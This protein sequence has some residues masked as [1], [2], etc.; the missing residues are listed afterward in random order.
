MRHT[1]ISLTPSQAFLMTLFG[2][3]ALILC[4]AVESRVQVV[5]P[6]AAPTFP[7]ALLPSAFDKPENVVVSPAHHTIALLL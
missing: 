3:P 1:S 7:L 5:S 2:A 4:W 6:H